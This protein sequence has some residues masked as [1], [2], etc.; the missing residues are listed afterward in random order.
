MKFQEKWGKFVGVGRILTSASFA[1]LGENFKIKFVFFR[2]FEN[3]EIS[4]KIKASWVG[5]DRPIRIIQRVGRAGSPIQIVAGRALD[6]G[7]FTLCAGP[8]LK[9]TRFQSS[10]GW[11]W[12]VWCNL[13]PR[14]SFRA[15]SSR[16]TQTRDREGLLLG[17]FNS[18]QKGTLSPN[19]AVARMIS[20]SGCAVVGWRQTS[21]VEWW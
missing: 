4:G 13:V 2:N 17:G 10:S 16:G 19:S 7:L 12:S 9:H 11:T 14:R 20:C 21:V 5:A 6:D 15:C 18:R 1:T 8:S 3:K